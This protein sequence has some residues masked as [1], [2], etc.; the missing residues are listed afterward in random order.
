[1]GL[2]SIHEL[3]TY[4]DDGVE[5]IHGALGH[6]RNLAPAELPEL[7]LRYRQHILIAKARLP[8]VMNPGI[9][10]Q[11]HHGVSNRALATAG[12]ACKTE[13]LARSQ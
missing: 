11:P 5:C 7:R 12:F 9:L 4:R 6:Q 8:P 10:D 1:M 2:K 13:D 3:G